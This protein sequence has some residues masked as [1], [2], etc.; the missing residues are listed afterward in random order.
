MAIFAPPFMRFN[1]ALAANFAGEK[2]SYQPSG[3]L[4]CIVYANAQLNL[5]QKSGGDIK[6]ATHLI[7]RN[8]P[9]C[10]ESLSYLAQGYLGEKDYASAKHYV[11]QLLDV[12][13]A[14]QWVV[15]LAAIYAM[16]ANDEYL[17]NVLTA[18]GLKLGL[19]VQS[20][21]K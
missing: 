10:I 6:A 2:V 9:R 20:Q 4:P 15:R 19:L 21:L 5:V 13:P 18:Q 7:E 12:A 14:R 1:S 16:G 17:K 8:H 3:S 11:Y